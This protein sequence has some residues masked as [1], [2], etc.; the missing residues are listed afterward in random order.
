[1]GRA[2][3]CTWL[4]ILTVEMLDFI[5][6]NPKEVMTIPLPPMSTRLPSSTYPYVAKI[7]QAGVLRKPAF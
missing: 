1:M 4:V 6:V 3:A 7:F 5:P 2:V